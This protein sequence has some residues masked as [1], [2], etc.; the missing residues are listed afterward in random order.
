MSPPCNTFLLTARINQGTNAAVE[1][2]TPEQVCALAAEKRLPITRLVR[3]AGVS[4]SKFYRWRVG[5]DIYL[6]QLTAIIETVQTYNLG[7]YENGRKA[8]RKPRAKEQRDG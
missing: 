4:R 8:G 7:E 1:I 2:L 5:G 3:L 6:S